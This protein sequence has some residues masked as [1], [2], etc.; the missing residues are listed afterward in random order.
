MTGGT[1][2]PS[3]EPVSVRAPALVRPH[4]LRQRWCDVAFLHWAVAP[5]TVGRAPPARSPAGRVRRPHLRRAGPVPDS[6]YRVRRMARPRRGSA[7]SWRPTCGSTRPTTTGRRGDRLPQPRRR[8]GRRGRRR[9]RWR[10]GCPT[11]GLG[12]ASRRR[13]RRAPVRRRRLRWPGARPPAAS[14]SG[15]AVRRT[16]ARSNGSSPPAGACTSR[17]LGRTCVR[18]QHPPAVA[19]A[20]G[21]A[22]RTRRRPAGRRR[23]GRSHP[24]A[25]RPRRVQ[26]GCGCDIRAAGAGDEAASRNCRWPAPRLLARR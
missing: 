25:A 2:S 15:R 21:R 14:R 12:W 5:E 26:R 1:P 23:A 8:P 16:T 4:L 17:T 18:P 20:H 11:A 9:P 10:S 24:A 22:A 19:A 6:R 7:R 13:W 3:P